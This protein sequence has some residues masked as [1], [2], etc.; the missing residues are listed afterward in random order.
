MRLL[1]LDMGTKR[2]GVAVSDELGWTTQALTVLK[3]KGEEQDLAAIE[4]LA[5]EHEVAGVVVGLPLNM[6]GTDGRL[7]GMVRRFAGLLSQRLGLPVHL[8]DERLTSWEAEGILKEAGVKPSKR[9]EVVD[10][11]A[12][13]I[14]L[15]SFLEARAGQTGEP[16]E[17]KQR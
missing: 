4:R 14:I 9:K 5:R 15:K 13:S 3:S 6:D 8:W 7:A 17:V 16:E 2:I 10:K 11:L 1:G 12:A